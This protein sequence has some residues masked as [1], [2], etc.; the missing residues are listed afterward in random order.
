MKFRDIFDAV[1]SRRL[2]A[3]S[4]VDLT[5]D[6]RL[7]LVVSHGGGSLAYSTA[8]QDGLSY[9][10]SNKGY[11]AFAIKSGF[12]FALADPVAHASD[13]K[14]LIND[15]VAAA[16]R[17]AFIQISLNTAA[18]LSTIG[19][20]VDPLGIETDLSLLDELFSGKK[21]QS[22]RYSAS[23]LR[24]NG[25]TISET[26]M[27]D[28]AI[29]ALSAS[30]LA[31]QN[32]RREMRF[33]NRPFSATLQQHMRRFILRD[34]DDT[35]LAFIDFDPI[36]S[37]S[38]LVGYSTAMKRRAPDATNHAE[39]G[40]TMHAANQF[41]NEGLSVLGFGLSPL[42]NQTD[43]E[44]KGRNVWRKSMGLA[45]ASPLINRTFFNMQGH[46]NFKQR[47]HGEQT[48]TFMAL[49][50]GSPMEAAALLRLLKLI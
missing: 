22:T 4:D 15:F 14:Q 47:F 36:F 32:V 48:Q 7:G 44:L 37:D 13:K 28:D 17:P 27:T 20:P 6:Q 40:I 23:W 18:H 39:I 1:S 49:G 46:A 25:F 21:Y 42:F 16:K 35:A 43:G 41:K 45:F 50:S 19:Y 8:V 29:A 33:A 30:W 11:I 2:S 5:L 24:R 12:A 26:P 31:R 34:P 38:K 9:F 3:V 10:G